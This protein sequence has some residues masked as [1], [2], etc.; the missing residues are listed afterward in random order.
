MGLEAAHGSVGVGPGMTGGKGQAGSRQ[1]THPGLCRHRLRWPEAASSG[2]RPGE[3]GTT[4]S[5]C[6]GKERK[7]RRLE[8]FA[9]EPVRRKRYFSCF[10]RLMNSRRHGRWDDGSRFPCSAGSLPTA[11]RA[12]GGEGEMGTVGR[13]VVPP[14]C[15]LRAGVGGSSPLPRRCTCFP[16]WQHHAR[17]DLS[18]GLTEMMRRE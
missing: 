15:Q 2:G 14:P 9:W 4:L 18:A 11:P 6:I 12:L 8:R 17:Q 13:P 5:S 7:R 16:V 10:P 1:P 3:K